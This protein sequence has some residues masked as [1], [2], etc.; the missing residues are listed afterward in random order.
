M[1]FL[2]LFW[3]KIL[4][5]FKSLL[6]FRA[7]TFQSELNKVGYTNFSKFW[8]QS[9]SS[10][11]EQVF[12]K[13]REKKCFCLHFANSNYNIIFFH[14]LFTVNIHSIYV[15]ITICYLSMTV[16]RRVKPRFSEKNYLPLKPTWCFGFFLFHS[17][18]QKTKQNYQISSSRAKTRSTPSQTCG[19]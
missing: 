14:F 9:I 16:I 13:R 8:L 17:Q 10:K 1:S 12:K 3:W 4:H 5:F 18:D 6:K 15:M 19:K 7:H 2:T 11:I